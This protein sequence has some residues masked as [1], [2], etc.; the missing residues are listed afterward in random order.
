ML[1]VESLRSRSL[2]GSFVP[3]DFKSWMS[4][5]AAAKQIK[6]PS[7]FGG[8]F[9]PPNWGTYLQPQLPNEN[10]KWRF[11]AFH[12]WAVTAIS[13]VSRDSWS[14]SIKW[15]PHANNDTWTISH[16]K[17]WNL[18][19][20][21]FNMMCHMVLIL[22]RQHVVASPHILARKPNQGVRTKVVELYRSFGNGS[23]RGTVFTQ[24]VGN[25]LRWSITRY[26]SMILSIYTYQWYQFQSELWNKL[27]YRQCVDVYALPLF[28]WDLWL[29]TYWF[30]G[31]GEWL[32]KEMFLRG[33][34]FLA[35]SPGVH[36][37]QV[38]GSY[39]WASHPLNR[40]I[41]CL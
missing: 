36:K 6:L 27:W 30:S 20:I 22:S 14:T 38:F 12:I 29:A 13:L 4:P 11:F 28:T 17:A 3:G 16:H 21:S 39:G 26:I 32:D 41:N 1:I 34:C 9:E 2:C 31:F 25:D 37:V 7:F 5:G 8:Q 24:H 19:R 23:E 15:I 10:V 35:M 33:A 18:A 40:G